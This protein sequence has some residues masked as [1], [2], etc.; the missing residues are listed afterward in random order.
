MR[1]TEVG[2]HV[3]VFLFSLFVSSISRNHSSIVGLGDCWRAGE[4][5][6]RTEDVEG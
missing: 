1:W 2:P 3:V 5:D 4:R 6:L